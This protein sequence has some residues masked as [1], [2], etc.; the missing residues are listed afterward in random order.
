MVT[1]FKHKKGYYFFDPNGRGE[2]GERIIDKQRI[3]QDRQNQVLDFIKPKP[4][5]ATFR[6]PM[7]VTL[8]RFTGLKSLVANLMGNVD[9][10]FQNTDFKIYPISLKRMERKDFTPPKSLQEFQQKVKLLEQQGTLDLPFNAP[11]LS[12]TPKPSVPKTTVKKPQDTKPDEQPPQGP[13]DPE[14][15]QELARKPIEKP[16]APSITYF[17]E[18]LPEK[19]NV[20]RATTHQDVPIPISTKKPTIALPDPS[21]PNAVTAL[22]ML[23][24]YKSRHWTKPIMDDVLTIAKATGLEFA[25]KNTIEYGGKKNITDISDLK[26]IPIKIGAHEYV[27]VEESTVYGKLDSDKVEDVDLKTALEELFDCKD[28]GK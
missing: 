8:M 19:Y 21:L 9:N 7:L 15:L 23:H 2:K 5:C 10:L 18:I 16:I 25:F 24:E 14:R 3:Q 17:H 27:V 26:D 1:V 13:Q 28:V 12:L 11:Q 20:L 22:A 6:P 4:F